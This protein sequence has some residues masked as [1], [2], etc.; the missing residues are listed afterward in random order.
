MSDAIET[1]IK[2]LG[3]Q[4]L[5]DLYNNLTGMKEFVLEQ[6]PD[7]CQQ[8]ITWEIAKAGIATGIL[9]IFI[10]ITGICFYLFIKE[11]NLDGD[12]TEKV[13]A[14]MI[15]GGLT[16]II[17]GITLIHVMEAFKAYITP[18]LFLLEHITSLIK[19]M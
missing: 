13:A 9:A 14:F 3:H 8:M 15:S 19:H 10:I 4:A 18:K 5:Q 17:S 7:I 6:A 16:V 11:K 2:D 12:M 1:S